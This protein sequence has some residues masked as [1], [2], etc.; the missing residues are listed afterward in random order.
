MGVKTAIGHVEAIFRYPVKSMRGE[1]LDT[2]QLGWHGVEG[3][4]RFAFRRLEDRSPFPWLTAGKLAE[5]LLF[6]PQRPEGGDLP[7][8][9][10]LPGGAVLPI[11]GDDLAQDV[12][13]RFGA[14]VQM[15]QLKDGI[16]D[17]A[18]ISVI[19]SDT[20]EEIARLSAV[21]QDA[22]RYRPNL[23][24]RLLQPGPFR[25]DQWL[26]SSLSFGEADDSPT[27]VVTRRDVRC[28]MVNLDPDTAVAAPQVLKAVVRAND[29][30]AGVYATVTRIGQL[31]VGQTIYLA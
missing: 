26:G 27:V 16:F 4:R 15:G 30:T 5:L 2:A 17:D 6:T 31:A 10:R 12:A 29:N 24:V 25:E 8:H 19:A 18:S 9:V 20:V 3:D 7:T 23:V 21:P 11:S 28:A 14:P 13:R 1:A 22:R